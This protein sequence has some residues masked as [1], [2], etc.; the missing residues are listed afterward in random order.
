M[1]LGPVEFRKLGLRC[2]AILGDVPL[3]DG[4]ATVRFECSTSCVTEP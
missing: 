1:R 4:L 3:H 2:H